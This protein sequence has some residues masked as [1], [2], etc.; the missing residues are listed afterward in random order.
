MKEKIQLRTH[1]T[2]RRRARIF[3]LAHSITKS[4]YGLVRTIEGDEEAQI[5]SLPH[6][7]RRVLP[8]TMRNAKYIRFEFN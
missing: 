3:P 2:R 8:V 1:I 5:V 4:K 7:H 6:D